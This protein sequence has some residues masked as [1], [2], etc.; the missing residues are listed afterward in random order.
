MFN[1]LRIPAIYT[2]ESSFCGNDVGPFANYHFSTFN[3]MQTGRDFCRTLT[4]YSNIQAPPTIL[5]NILNDITQLYSHYKEMNDI[6]DT[7][8]KDQEVEVMKNFFEKIQQLNTQNTDL[9]IKHIR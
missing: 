5:N 8:N 1:E 6:K 2:M 3:L 4:I 7:F 9:K